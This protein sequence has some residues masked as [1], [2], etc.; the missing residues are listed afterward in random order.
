MLWFKELH[1]SLL[2]GKYPGQAL[3]DYPLYKEL[4]QF[5]S[6]DKSQYQKVDPKAIARKEEEKS[7][8]GDE[9]E[10]YEPPVLRDDGLTWQ[11]RGWKRDY[12]N[13]TDA[14]RLTMPVDET[15]ALYLWRISCKTN[16][17]FYKLVVAFVIFFRE[18]L[19]EIGWQ[20]R[21][22]SEEIDLE[23]KPDLA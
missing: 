4:L 8:R 20:K 15:F 16:A 14:D 13:L 11:Q 23:K 6:K 2:R 18:C 21:I 9:E 12:A 3:E 19:N 5:S 1:E 22:E 17:Q 7:E 10:P